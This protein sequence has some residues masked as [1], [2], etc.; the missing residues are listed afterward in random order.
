M[1]CRPGKC[2]DTTNA[3]FS[4]FADAQML[5]NRLSYD[6]AATHLAMS[7]ISVM[8]QVMQCSSKASPGRLCIQP[9]TRNAPL[10]TSHTTPDTL[11]IFN[12]NRA[13]AGTLCHCIQKRATAGNWFSDSDHV[14]AARFKQICAA[15]HRRLRNNRN[16]GMAPNNRRMLCKI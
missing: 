2:L 1:G 11:C 5:N 12:P 13:T 15:H 8:A 3:Q 4:C 14:V 16:T 6:L 7:C 9:Q 10:Y